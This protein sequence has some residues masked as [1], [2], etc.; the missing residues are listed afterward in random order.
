MAAPIVVTGATGFIGTALVPALRAAGHP[1]TALTRDAERARRVLGDATCVTADLQSPG[2][3]TSALAGA[4]AI[5]HLAGAPIAGQRW[6]ARYKQ[7]L[8]DSRVETTRTLVEAIAALP[9]ASRPRALIAS[10]GIDYYPFAP[11]GRA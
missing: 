9:A 8:R 6:D 1:V 2:P 5:V 10:S 4:A 11:D 7:R 3:W